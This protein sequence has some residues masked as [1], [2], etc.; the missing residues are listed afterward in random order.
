MK[1]AMGGSLRMIRLGPIAGALERRRCSKR[2]SFS[3]MA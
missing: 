2:Y 1:L 3:H